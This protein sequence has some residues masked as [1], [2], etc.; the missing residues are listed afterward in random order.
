MKNFIFYFHNVRRVAAVKWLS[1]NLT[2]FFFFF[3]L[4]LFSCRLVA[5]T[6]GDA[7]VVV[8]FYEA[9]S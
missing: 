9:E 1:L 8:Y 3:I 4:Y 7:A 2:D 6:P 5:I